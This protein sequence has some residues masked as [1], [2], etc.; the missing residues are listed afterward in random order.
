VTTE[1]AHEAYSRRAADYIDAVGRIEHAAQW[2]RDYLLAWARSID[3]RVIDVGCGPGQ[4]TN[5]FHEAGIDI[6]G[7][8]PSEVFIAEAKRSYPDVHYRLGR[9]EGLDL[10][11]SSA[12]GILAWFSLIHVDPATVQEPLREFARCLVPGGSVALGFFDGPAR[13]PFDHAITTAY[14]WSVNALSSE[15][16][17]AG[18]DVTDSVTRHGPGV[19]RQGVIVARLRDPVSA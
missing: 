13:E 9:A 14:Y 1:A 12:G 19:R 4:W 17:Q 2:D 16:D 11:D 7:V 3:G 18:F 6:G 5:Y 15:L 8:D 10:A